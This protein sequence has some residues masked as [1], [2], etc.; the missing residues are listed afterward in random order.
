MKLSYLSIAPVLQFLPRAGQQAASTK[1]QASSADA[2]SVQS[3]SSL[4]LDKESLSM[5]EDGERQS[6][7]PLPFSN[8]AKLS[9]SSFSA[10][11]VLRASG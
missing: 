2:S 10:A 9:S 3:G 7:A 4:Q 5:N 1:P 8:H 11:G 6:L